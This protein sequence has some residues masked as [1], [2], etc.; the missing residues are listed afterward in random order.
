VSRSSRVAAVAS[1]RILAFLAVLCVWFALP[2]RALAAEPA[3]PVGTAV[4]S[5]SALPQASAPAAAA[6]APA[7]AVAA[8]PAIAAPVAPAASADP[9]WLKAV[10]ERVVD[11]VVLIETEYGTGSGF[12]FRNNRLIATALHVV[13]DAELIVVQASDGRR[14]RGRVVAYARKHDV[15]LVELEQALPGARVLEPYTGAVDIGENV[16]VIG[17]PFSGLEEQ[18]SELRGLLNWSL[19]QGIVSAVTGSWLQTDAAIN[20]GNSGGP[21]LNARGEVLGVVS[22]KLSNAQ[23]ISVAARIGRVLELVPEIGKQPPPRHD[24]RFEGVEVGFIAQISHDTIEGFSIGGGSRL[25]KRYPLRLRLGLLAGNVEPHQADVLET[26]LVRVSGELTMGVAL[27]LG[28]VELS[29]ALGAALFYDHE[30][31]SSLR[32]DDV[33]CATPPCLVNGKVLRSGEGSVHLLPAAELTLDFHLLRVG[34]A[35]ELALA[36]A[37]ESQH[38]ILVGVTF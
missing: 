25:F 23:G 24:W 19:T 36:Q 31:N 5:P 14:L 28:P 4:P 33:T 30:T 6:T 20:P 29:P 1:A 3:P 13:D 38:R 11:S 35:F 7:P 17:H 2:L 8:P 18:V 26:H 21:V 12:F 10:Y 9:Q 16:L 37:L 15:A 22:A 27:P 34:Y 32:I